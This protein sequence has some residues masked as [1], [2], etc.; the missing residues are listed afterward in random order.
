MNLFYKICFLSKKVMFKNQNIFFYLKIIDNQS[1]NAFVISLKNNEISIFFRI[2]IKKSKIKERRL[3]I[4]SY[5]IFL[6]AV[7]FCINLFSEIR[8]L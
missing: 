1:L 5:F 6:V 4:F 3:L 2:V 8:T 7:I